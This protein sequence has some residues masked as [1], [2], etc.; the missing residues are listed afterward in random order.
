MKFA[1]GW[2][3]VAL[4]M[5]QL[6]LCPSAQA[7]SVTRE[8]PAGTK[9]FLALDEG[10]SSKRKDGEVGEVIPCRVWRDVD[11]SGMAFIKAGTPATCKV[12]QVKR[13][14]IGGVE[15]KISIAAL[16]TKAVNGE[17]VIL[18]GGYNKEGYGRKAVAWTVGLLLLWPA[19]FITGGN[20]ELPPG[21]IFDTYTAN[22][23]AITAE[24]STW[25]SAINLADLME[26]YS[27]EFL[28]DEFLGQ[29]KPKAFKFR[30]AKVGTFPQEFRIDNVN[31]K[32][33]EPLVLKMGALEQQDDVTASIGEVALKPL[34][35]HFQKGI[36]RVQVAYMDG[37]TRVAKEVLIE[38]QM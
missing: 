11:A 6:L 5:M 38:I 23:L 15:G 2:T 35:K 19:L 9:V 3:A 10:V 12:D 28:I 36:N 14:N 22:P 17:L 32:D 18:S 31:D 21:T 25:G 24:L 27:V 29:E 37:E 1:I 8:L 13:R 33:I 7:A 34:A 16:E 26:D 30:V 4:A 20:A